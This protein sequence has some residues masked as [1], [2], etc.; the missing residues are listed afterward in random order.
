[1]TRVGQIWSDNDSRMAG[2]MVRVEA[3]GDR[4]GGVAVCRVL[5]NS[6]SQQQRLD[7]GDPTARDGRGKLTEIAIRRMRPTSTGWRLVANAGD[8]AVAFLE[9]LGL[10]A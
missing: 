9:K 4:D 3:V 2:R 5:T 7:A 6:D 8:E 1:M 10:P